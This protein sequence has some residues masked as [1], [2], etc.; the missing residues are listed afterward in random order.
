MTE[1][2]KLGDLKT[3]LASPAWRLSSLY[4]IIA[5]GDDGDDLVVTFKPNAA[6]SMQMRRLWHR[7]LILKARQMGFSTLVCMLW[8]DT[9]AWSKSPM[10]CAIVAQDKEAAE[11]L[12]AKITFAYDSLPDEVRAMLPLARRTTSLLEFKH[13]GSKV[14][15]KTSVRGG[16]IH[17]L[18]ISE[19]GKICAKAPDKAKEVVTGSIPAVPKSGICII[20]STAEGQDGKFYEYTQ[21]AAAAAE[22]AKPLTPMDWRFHFYPWWQMSEYRLDPRTVDLSEVDRRYILEAEGKIGR[23]LEPAQW[24]WYFATLRALF[25]GEA[26]LMWQEY[27]THW[28]EAFQV[29]TEGCYYAAQLSLA[30]QQGR[31]RQVLPFEPSAPVN[32]FWDLGRGDMTTVWFHQRV[33][34]ENRFVR[35]YENTGE[36]LSHYIRYLQETG[37]VFGKHFLPHEAAYRRLGKDA[38]TNQTLEEMFLDLMPGATTVIVPRITNIGTGIQQT[39]DAFASS[40]FCE[41]GCANG[42]Q[43]LGNY[44]KKWNKAL[45]CWAGEPMH[46]DNSHGADGYRQFGQTLASGEVFP[47]LARASAGMVA[48]G[49]NWRKRRRSA[50][51]A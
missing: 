14:I 21:A 20:E 44:R 25:A 30:R 38:D 31:I 2:D 9:A 4:K 13:N 50:M 29:S 12:F 47:E 24:A 40:W 22:S 39:R 45:G 43:R 10:R 16:T 17:R 27:P 35:Y 3:R 41:T 15:V 7:S 5:K 51:A 48:K 37:Y 36:D 34:P 18:H 19:F 1:H 32:T 23:R 8:L 42:L 11:E 26:P 28:K 6:Q 33:G 49:E 46:D